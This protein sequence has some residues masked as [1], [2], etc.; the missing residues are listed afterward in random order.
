[1]RSRLSGIDYLT[2]PVRAKIDDY[3]LEYQYT[4]PYNVTQVSNSLPLE[5]ILS[6]NY[7]C[8][9]N[10][11]GEISNAQVR[12]GSIFFEGTDEKGD[13]VSME[14]LSTAPQATSN[15]TVYEMPGYLSQL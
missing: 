15:G 12:F 9:H 11:D 6:G 14:I 3:E 10:M 2:V 1:M 8:R 4:G 13:Y 7:K 5:S